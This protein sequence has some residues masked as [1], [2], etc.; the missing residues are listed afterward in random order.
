MTHDLETLCVIVDPNSGD[1]V[2]VRV[3]AAHDL[4]YTDHRI[5]G[6]FRLDDDSEIDF[7]GLAPTEQDKINK[8]IEEQI[9]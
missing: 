2:S 7:S 3:W 8:S 9:K 6:V 5:I 4:P 1:N